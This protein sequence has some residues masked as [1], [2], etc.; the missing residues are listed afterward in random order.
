MPMKEMSIGA[1]EKEL[2]GHVPLRS[3][4]D[5]GVDYDELVLCKR[6]VINCAVF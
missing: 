6:M 1:P 4:L 5:G 2:N 3:L